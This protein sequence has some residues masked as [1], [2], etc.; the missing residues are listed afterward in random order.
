MTRAYGTKTAM[1]A[2]PAR[3]RAVG[4]D[5]HPLATSAE[6]AD[7]RPRA[8][9]ALTAVEEPSAPT[10]W[11]TW[12]ITPGRRSPP[13]T[14][15][16]SRLVLVLSLVA[17][18]LIAVLAGLILP[19]V[20][21]PDAPYR[22]PVFP[23]GGLSA[24]VMLLTYLWARF[25][26]SSYRAAA[27]AI[28][29]N[30]I[31]SPL[32]ASL[33]FEPHLFSGAL[34]GLVLASALFSTRVVA[35]L[36]LLLL[37]AGALVPPLSGY[38]ISYDALVPELVVTGMVGTLLVVLPWHYQRLERS[39]QRQLNQR[40]TELLLEIEARKEAQESLR[41]QADLQAVLVQEINHRVRNN[42]GAVLGMLAA[43]RKR[44]KGGAGPSTV[45]VLDDID[46]R[47]RG[48][49]AAHDT[50]VA[51]H[52]QPLPLSEL[53]ESVLKMA[54]QLGRPFGSASEVLVQPSSVLVSTQ[55]TQHLALVL[56]E[57]VTNSLKH[58]RS[59]RIRHEV[60]IQRL[61][62]E[63]ILR[64]RDNGRGYPESVIR[65]ARERGHIGLELIEG[66]VAH[67]LRGRVELTNDHGAVAILRFPI[68][69][70]REL[71]NRGGAPP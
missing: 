56:A 45:E 3:R 23:I 1:H 18:V 15:V 34:V 10:T 31:V 64:Y 48:M 71:S 22:H 27:L 6:T 36:V 20:F 57:L 25:G 44:A 65:G 47:I 4:P 43:E 11:L 63:A 55:Q 29:L 19:H 51:H 70:E 37:L 32:T 35:A 17:F 14:E 59:S 33:V 21:A 58:G 46:R 66:L 50:L 30:C 41:K 69:E 54:A 9:R 52:W 28:V 38:A 7:G 13:G 42:V 12:L 67:S 61:G 49:G 2:A 5:Q 68:P 40:N 62:N 39:R 53:C 8:P 26:P 16:Q 60:E 24:I